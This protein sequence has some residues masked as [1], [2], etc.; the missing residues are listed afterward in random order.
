[1]I[2]VKRIIKTTIFFS[3]PVCLLIL[4]LESI[5]QWKISF[6]YCLSFVIGLF[7]GILNLLITDFGL[8]KLEFS[9]VSRPKAYYSLLHILKL[10]IYG[11]VLYFSTKLLGLYTSFLCAFGM[12]FNKII[13]YYINLIKIPKEDNK[14]KVEELDLPLEI[15]NKLKQNNYEKVN[16]IINV[17]RKK[18]L[19]FLNDK[20]VELIIKSLK[21][22]ELFIKGEL[23]AIIDNDND[24]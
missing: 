2:D 1:M 10:V 11:V 20:E 5:I 3:I 4:I 7:T 15:I 21:K 22:Y 24:V 14:R 12:V 23:E 16:D 6:F 19:E 8:R 17:N 18:L 13:I 9:E